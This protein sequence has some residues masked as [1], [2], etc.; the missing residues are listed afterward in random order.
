MSASGIVAGR[1]RRASFVSK[2]EA[3][4]LLDKLREENRQRRY[5]GDEDYE[6]KRAE[7][8]ASLLTRYLRE[9][10]DKRGYA[11][12]LSYYHFWCKHFEGKRLAQ[13]TIK[14]V[15]NARQ[16][17]REGGPRGHRIAGTINRYVTWLQQALNWAVLD[18]A[19]TVNPIAALPRCRS[20]PI[21]PSSSRPTMNGAR[22]KPSA[23]LTRNGCASGFSPACDKVSNLGYNGHGSILITS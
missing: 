7:S 23:R 4:A 6:R 18:D 8:V 22:R 5:L 17:L 3:R 10:K 1:S 11:N 13:I 15:R 19:I 9:R 12:E 21:S 16:A 2:E 14:E 20:R